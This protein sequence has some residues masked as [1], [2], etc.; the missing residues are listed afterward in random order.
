M[1]KVQIWG[2]SPWFFSREE[3]TYYKKLN[4]KYQQ[5]CTQEQVNDRDTIFAVSKIPSFKKKN[6]NKLLETTVFTTLSLASSPL[7]SDLTPW[8]L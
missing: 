6:E 7:P 8:E 4:E 2:F 3:P 1:S 5:E